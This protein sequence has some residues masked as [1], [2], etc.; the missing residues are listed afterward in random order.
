MTKKKW[1]LLVVLALLL[2][3]AGFLLPHTSF[4]NSENAGTAAVD[5]SALDGAQAQPFGVMP[6]GG[7]IWD[8]GPMTGSEA[9]CWSN[10]TA[11]QNFAEDVSFAAST[12]IVSIVIYTCIGPVPGSTV[13]IKIRHDDGTGNPSNTP[14]YDASVTPTSWLPAAGTGGYAVT[15]DLPAPFTATAGTTYWIGLS[16]DGFELGQYSV[17]TPDD[18]HMAQFSGPTFSFHTAVGDQMFQLLGNAAGCPPKF[19]DLSINKQGK[20]VISF[21]TG[22]TPQALTLYII[23]SNGDLITLGP[24]NFPANQCRNIK[25]ITLT[26]PPI[27]AVVGVLRKADAAPIWDYIIAP[28]APPPSE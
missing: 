19:I 18:G 3:I 6:A 13:H 5:A 17:Q 26:N 4:A 16:G 20:L 7:I 12:D 23:R 8:Y 27:Y 2:G 22:D 14:L 11:S 15:A 9:G 21:S 10:Y 28:P 1:S 24:Y 25:T